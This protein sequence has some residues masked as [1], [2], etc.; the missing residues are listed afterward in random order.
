MT[1]QE[2]REQIE[3]AGI[4]IC[5][6]LAAYDNGTISREVMDCYRDTFTSGILSLPLLIEVEVELPK[7]PYHPLGRFYDLSN[8]DGYMGTEEMDKPETDAYNEAQM[9]M[10]KAGY[11][12][13]EF[14]KDL[15]EEVKE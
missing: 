15:L 14:T 6:A 12:K 11:R 10:L 3:W 13:T 7:N 8:R 1:I 2:L 9:D 4:T 5:F